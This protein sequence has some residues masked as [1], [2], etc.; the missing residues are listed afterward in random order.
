MLIAFL[1]LAML[2]VVHGPGD[3]SR[4]R[5]ETHVVTAGARRGLDRN[6]KLSGM[7]SVIQRDR[8]NPYWRRRRRLGFR[9]EAARRENG[10]IVVAVAL[11]VHRELTQVLHHDLLLLLTGGLGAFASIQSRC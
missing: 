9:A 4:Q 6:Q 10:H 2:R 5:G 8:W 7:G 11:D 3:R 1:I